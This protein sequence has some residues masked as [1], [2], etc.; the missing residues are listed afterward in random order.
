MK[1]LP[2]IKNYVR[3][4]F[5]LPFI[6]LFATASASKHS[7]SLGL[8]VKGFGNNSFKVDALNQLAEELFEEN[9]AL[10]LSYANQALDLAKK[11]NYNQGLS[12]SYYTLGRLNANYTLNFYKS[13]AY[14][15]SALKLNDEKNWQ[16]AL[17]IYL[18]LAFVNKRQKD[19]TKA[20]EYYNQ[21]I[22]IA[23]DKKVTSKLSVAYS[24]LADVYEE[25]GDLKNTLSNLEK[26]IELEKREG[27]RN[28]QP[29]IFV[30]FG[31][32]FELKEQYGLAETYLRDALTDFIKTK[33]YRWASYTH[34]Q[35]SKVSMLEGNY[36]VALSYANQGLELARQHNLNKE[37]ADNYNALAMVYEK[38]GDYKNAYT[39]YKALQTL[40][41]SIFNLERTREIAG[42]VT[43]YETNVK[44]EKLALARIENELKENQLKKTTIALWGSV[45]CLVLLTILLV[46][47]IRNYRIKQNINYELQNRDE[48]KTLELDEIIKQLNSEVTEHQITKSKLEVMNAELN[49]FMFRSSHDL[50][51]PLASITGL[52][53]LASGNVSEKE[54][55]EYLELISKSTAS[56]SS[57]LD[58]L[59][60]AT[61]VAHGKVEPHE[62]NFSEFVTDIIGHL[63]NSEQAKNIGF[64]VELTKN[65]TFFSDKSLFRTIMHNLI[66]NSI[67]YKNSSVAYPY[68]KISAEKLQRTVKITLS[69]NGQGIPEE[70][71]STVFN[72]FVRANNSTKGS[73]L[74]LYLVKKSVLKLG[75]TISLQSEEGKGTIFEITIPETVTKDSNIL[76]FDLD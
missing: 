72:M 21:A 57:L 12:Q 1:V 22:K 71:K 13:V 49:N 39:N 46:I 56:L 67:N 34:S 3:L 75:G 35:L 76:L 58:E 55:L 29:K 50:K 64:Y 4:C 31:H 8:A 19:Y 7:D 59:A 33:N 41:D 5:I 11:V 65:F 48:L 32:Y 30:S 53:T 62:I 44:E 69:D 37:L 25:Q 70:S 26:I 18:Q 60:A 2:N 15:T 17:N 20:V 24:Y 23:T 14:L 73:G 6:F 74:G 16:L 27:F 68:V 45:I 36:K 43:A 52:T 40:T 10:S 61:K 54:R 9:H 66:E 63:K 28:T 47:I 38:T 42:I 51:G